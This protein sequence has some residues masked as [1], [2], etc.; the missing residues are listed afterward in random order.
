M[1]KLSEKENLVEELQT[2][3]RKNLSEIPLKHRLEFVADKLKNKSKKCSSII[4]KL[5]NEGN[6][7]SLD[8]LNGYQHS[9]TTVYL[10]KPF[11]NRFWDFLFPLFE[12]LIEIRESEM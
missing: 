4:V 8:V 11:I 7:F 12:E 5:T 1:F 10:D 6:E 9:K 2:H 3:K